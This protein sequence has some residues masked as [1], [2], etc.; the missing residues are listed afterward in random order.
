[1][2][3]RAL[4][5]G[6]GSSV[7]IAWE[8]G[9]AAGLAD[10]GIDLTLADKI[11]GT[12]AGSFVGAELASG[13]APAE[14]R[15]RLTEGAR[16]R[17]DQSPTPNA[18]PVPEPVP[19]LTKLM[20]FMV[21]V[22]KSEAE[23]LQLRAEIGAYALDA[24][25][26]PEEA[27]VG[28][29][30]CVADT[31]WPAKYS[32]TAIDAQDGRFVVFDQSTGAPL[33]RGVASSCSVPGLFPPITVNGRR[34]YDGGIRSATNFDLA[35]GFERVIAVA[36]I[37]S[38]AAAFMAARIDP[39][40]AQLRRS[41]AHVEL[42]TPDAASLDAFGPNLMDASRQAA[43]LEAGVKQGRAEAVRIRAVWV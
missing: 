14:L 35:E 42:I 36:V 4:V 17:A 23:A 30:A 31:P 40:L 38:G 16:A 11:V 39:E 6:G 9:L 27:C 41:G 25:T 15:E 20:E 22:P 34:Y 7:G 10:E 28:F 29:F 5:L 18:L 24:A 33:D 1:M 19:D 13:R 21:R 26:I 37:P 32:C 8:T 43:V 12:S 2:A 3:K